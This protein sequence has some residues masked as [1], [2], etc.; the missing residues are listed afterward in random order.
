MNSQQKKFGILHRFLHDFLCFSKYLLV[1]ALL[2][3]FCFHPLSHAAEGNPPEGSEAWKVISE[4]F[5]EE[6]YLPELGCWAVVYQ[7]KKE[8]LV[9]HRAS[10]QLEAEAA[11]KGESEL[12]LIKCMYVRKIEDIKN[13]ESNH[14]LYIWLDERG[15]AEEKINFTRGYHIYHRRQTKLSLCRNH[16]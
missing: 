1:F 2:T 13:S 9:M 6:N 3:T 16:F 10:P 4:Y 5:G 8:G 14:K 7:Y 12:W 15:M 11:K